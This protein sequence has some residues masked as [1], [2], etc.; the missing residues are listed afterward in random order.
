MC[1]L[2]NS[3]LKEVVSLVN[4]SI[5]HEGPSRVLKISYILVLVITQVNT[6]VRIHSVVRL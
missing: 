1:F 2:R 3:I 6:Y 5:E 4:C